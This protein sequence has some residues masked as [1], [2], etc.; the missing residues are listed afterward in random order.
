[1]NQSTAKRP[2]DPIMQSGLRF[3]HFQA[4][5]YVYDIDRHHDPRHRPLEFISIPDALDYAIRTHQRTGHDL[6]VMDRLAEL[7]YSIASDD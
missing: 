5:F 4:P 3:D 1:M 7:I 2:S 6:T